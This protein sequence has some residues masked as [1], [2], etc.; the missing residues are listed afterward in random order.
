[1]RA[2]F[3]LF[4]LLLTAGCGE[5]PTP[6]DDSSNGPGSN[7]KTTPQKPL[8][9]RIVKLF[10]G[11][12]GWKPLNNP[13]RVEAFRLDPYASI[14]EDDD[15]SNNESAKEFAGFRITAGP[16]EVDGKTATKLMQ[17]LSQPDIYGWDFAKGCEF[18][19][20]VGVRYVGADTTT[21]ILFCFSCDELRIVRDGKRIGGEDTDGARTALVNIAK[22]IFPKDKVIQ[23]LRTA[24]EQSAIDSAEENKRNSQLRE[25]GRLMPEKAVAALIDHETDDFEKIIASMP[26]TRDQ[27]RALLHFAGGP[28]DSW[29]S[30]TGVEINVDSALKAY[31]KDELAGPVEE[32]LLGENRLIR[33]GAARLWLGWRSPLADWKPEK[34]SELQSACLTVMQEA[35]YYPTRQRA[36]SK[37]LQWASHLPD[38]E[39]E[40]RLRQGLHDP[41][42]SVRRSAMLTAGQLKRDSAREYL[43]LQLSGERPESDALPEVPPAERTDVADGFDK[44]IGKRPEAEVAALALGYLEAKE[45]AERIRDRLNLPELA[46]QEPSPLYEVSLALLGDLDLLK[47]RHFN[48]GERNNE[49]QLAAV[50]AVVRAKG[51]RVDLVLGYKQA[52]HWWEEDRVVDRVRTMLLEEKAPGEALLKNCTNLKQLAAWHEDHGAEFRKRFDEPAEPATKSE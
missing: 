21:E 32:A 34:L 10:G 9:A 31:D 39:V 11:Q 3:L 29:S 6:P 25:W 24:E 44:V 51:R 37:L 13:V 45:A 40:R 7:T 49:L 20:G 14:N 52:T 38:D 12:E 30:F 27:I 46:D 17:T 36:Q 18:S 28:N 16:V 4:A 35:R 19:P 41:H 8:D 5:T 23:G 22:A 33:R 1:M 47:P 2:I 42:P 26:K 15:D 43:L 48:L 50:D